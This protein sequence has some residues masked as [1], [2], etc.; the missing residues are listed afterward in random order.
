MHECA[1]EAADSCG[2]RPTT[3]RPSTT[4]APPDT[5]GGPSSCG[6]ELEQKKRC[7]GGTVNSLSNSKINAD[8]CEALCKARAGVGN[9]CCTFHAKTSKCR[10]HSGAFKGPSRSNKQY[11]AA[12]C[13]GATAA[14]TVR[15]T[16][17]PTTPP[18]LRPTQAPGRVSCENALEQKKTFA[19]STTVFTRAPRKQVN[20]STLQLVL[21]PQ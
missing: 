10:L 12:T 3:A 18:T 8:D 1:K 17:A 7:S 20:S 5:T 19:A 21:D 9:Q 11:Y 6:F 16:E 13:T 14:P 15:P 2:T 4:E